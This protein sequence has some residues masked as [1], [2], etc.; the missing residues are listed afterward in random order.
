MGRRVNVTPAIVAWRKENP[1][2]LWLDEKPGR[3]AL[4][5]AEVAITKSGVFAWLHG[6]ALPKPSTMLQLADLTGIE[7]RD[8]L[9]WWVS[10]PGPVAIQTPDGG[11]AT[12]RRRSTPC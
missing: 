11:G 8:W 5:M 2:R 6:V 9:E 3:F 4:L 7:P 10:R 12:K 1:L